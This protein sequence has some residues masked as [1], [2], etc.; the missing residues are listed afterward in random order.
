M[1][2]RTVFVQLDSE[3]LVDVPLLFLLPLFP[4]EDFGRRN[5]PLNPPPIAFPILIP[6][7]IF[8]DSDDPPP[9]DA[10]LLFVKE[11]AF[12]FELD[13]ALYALALLERLGDIEGE[14]TEDESGLVVDVFVEEEESTVRMSAL[15]RFDVFSMRVSSSSQ[16]RMLP[17]SMP[18]LAA[19]ADGVA[20]GLPEE[21]DGLFID[22]PDE[23]GLFAFAAH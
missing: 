11:G 10:E 9:A 20:A 7:E 16:A 8:R 14:V 13:F 12:E 21:V 22:A 3:A 23:E 6:A 1:R 19:A 5:I 17:A 18:P 15:T 4:D 2:G